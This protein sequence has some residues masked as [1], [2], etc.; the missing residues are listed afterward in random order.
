[1]LAF[2]ISNSQKL[3]VHPPRPPDFSAWFPAHWDRQF[4]S[5]EEA[6]LKINQ[7]YWTPHLFEAGCHG[8]LRRFMKSAL[9]KYRAVMIFFLLFSALKIL[10]SIISWP[11]PLR[12]PTASTP[13][14]SYSLFLRFS[15]ASPLITFLI[16]YVRKFPSTLSRDVLDCL[17]PAVL[18]FQLTLEWLKLPTKTR[19]WEQ[20]ASSSCLKKSLPTYS[21]LEGLWQMLQQWHHSHLAHH[22][23]QGR[24]LCIFSA[25]SRKVQLTLS[26]LLSCPF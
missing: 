21:W 18:T 5:R 26:T 3:L 16:T 7:L 9:L 23:S 8:V 14:T 25:L 4:L 12:P 2:N 20:K 22:Q 24:V 10:N 13:L 11:L 6:S 19:A 1:M 17:C 15:R